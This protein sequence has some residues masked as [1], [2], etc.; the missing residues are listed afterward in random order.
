MPDQRVMSLS[1]FIVAEKA[2]LEAFR[3]A[4]QDEELRGERVPWNHTYDGWRDMYAAWLES[5]DDA[6]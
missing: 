6:E 2:G 3:R 1:Q 5:D 4:K